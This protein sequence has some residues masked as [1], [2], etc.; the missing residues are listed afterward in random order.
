VGTLRNRLAR[1]LA[2]IAL[3][4]S[5]AFATAQVGLQGPDPV[6]WTATYRDGQVELVGA[7]EDGWY[8]YS[9]QKVEDGPFPT[10][11][12]VPDGQPLEIAGPPKEPG[13]KTKFDKGFEKEVQIWEQTATLEVPIRLTK[14]DPGPVRL[15]VQ[16]QV[17]ND[18]GCLPPKTK[19][20][21]FLAEGPATASASTADNAT[22]LPPDPARA[23]GLLAFLG[24]ALGAGFVSLLTPCVFPMI[25]ITV[26]IFS[27]KKA[28]EGWRSGIGQALAFCFGIIST[29]TLIGV[30]S[31][32]LFSAS[33]LQNFANNPWLNLAM[34]TLFVLLALSLFGVYELTLPSGLANRINA[35]G[36]GGLLGPILMG[37]VFSITSFTCTMPFVGTLLVSAAQGDLLYP[38]IGMLGFSTA[39]ALPFFGLALFPQALSKLPRSG[40]WLATVKAFMGFIEL[41]AAVKFFSSVDL[42]WQ[43]GWMTKPVFL[44]LWAVIMAGAGAYLFG[45]F[46]IPTV[47]ESGR[48]GI[49]RL[50]FGA[51][52]W[53]IAFWC[54]S[55]MNGTSM[56]KLES[57]LPPDPYPFREGSAQA[58][59]A[60]KDD[61][62]LDDL[63]AALARAKELDKP[64][65]V[66]FT[67]VFCTNCRD[68]EKNVFPQA[69]VQAEFEKMVLA[70]LY[71][72]RVD[73]PKDQKYQALKEQWTGSV[74]NPMYVILRPDGSRA[75][76]L[77]YEPDVNRF[78]AFL[79]DGLAKAESANVATA[80]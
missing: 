60:K 4:A 70:K 9:T 31:A 47:E 79:R 21:E 36:K 64:V 71:T 22:P 19:E 14:N 17:C 77:P 54:L 76:F 34:G 25:P 2:A 42:G 40:G 63:D 46:R 67:G 32:V 26:S 39:F 13:L 48:P 53:A 11:L 51:G 73:N 66:D 10:T 59:L 3:V 15:A 18:E 6:Q 69:P 16:Y 28:S 12:S 41:A 61:T 49:L 52:S 45:W 78:A 74:A 75:A 72:D 20:V 27:K 23:G 80:R 65:F 33:G 37:L 43:W 30:L 35:H 38:I 1:V 50:A 44:G 55:A 62:W 7:I 8:M 29:F 57:F 56:G 58:A 24:I 5:T 68:M